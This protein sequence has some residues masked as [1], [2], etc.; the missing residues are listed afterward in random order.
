M[1]RQP[2]HNQPASRTTTLPVS[3]ALWSCCRTL[4][5]TL[6]LVGKQDGGSLGVTSAPTNKQGCLLY[7]TDATSGLRFLVDTGAEVSVLPANFL[8]CTLTPMCH[9]QAVNSSN[10][11]VYRKR[12]ILIN[13]DLQRTFSWI[14]LVAKVSHTIL[15]TGFPVPLLSPSRHGPKENSM[16]PPQAFSSPAKSPHSIRLLSHFANRYSRLTGTC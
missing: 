8:D 12:F 2:R 4:H 10:I 1:N 3:P 11:P 9:L 6:Q 16:T 5:Q 7:I 15:G 14:F 13:L